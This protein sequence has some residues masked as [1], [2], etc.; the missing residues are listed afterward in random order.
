MLI[1]KFVFDKM[2]I[3]KLSLTKIIS[4]YH[5]LPLKKKNSSPSVLL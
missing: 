1:H 4:S 5:K 2:L 3:H